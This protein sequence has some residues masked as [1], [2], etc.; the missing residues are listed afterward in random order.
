MAKSPKSAAPDGRRQRSERSKKAIT[1]AVMDM[2]NEGNL[3]PTAQQVS[4]RAGVGIRSVFRHFEDM[5]KLFE[6]VDEERRAQWEAVFLGGDREGSLE[7][8]ITHAAEQHAKG[9]EMWGNLM[10]CNQAQRW[11]YD[12]LKKNYARYQRGLRKDLDNWLPELK[13]LDLPRREAIDAIASFEFWN[14]LRELQGLSSKA[15]RQLVA[16]LISGILAKS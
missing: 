14:R 7:E 8:R 13:E 15:S 10:R 5:E 11:R 1:D 16:G 2:I 6:V 3:I 12:V 4:E 9:Y